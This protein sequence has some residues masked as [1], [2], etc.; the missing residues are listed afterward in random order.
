[1]LWIW[2]EPVRCSSTTLPC[3]DVTGGTFRRPRQKRNP[4]KFVRRL[5]SLQPEEFE[6]KNS[7]RLKTRK[8]LLKQSGNLQTCHAGNSARQALHLVG[9]FIIHAPRCLIYGRAHQILQ[10]L[11]ILTFE[12]FLLDLH[13]QHLLL[14]VH[15]YGDH[16]AASGSLYRHC[17]DLTLPV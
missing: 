11:V 13:F 4:D 17:V 8:E 15:L 16:S 5:R 7:A 6:S 10:H 3:D 2:T 9:Q 12:Y 1:M 14:A